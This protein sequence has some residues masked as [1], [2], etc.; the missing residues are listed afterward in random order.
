[1]NLIF[2]HIK[3]KNLDSTIERQPHFT[4]LLANNICIL[5]IISYIYAK[6]RRNVL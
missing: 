4:K 6:F 5:L 2:I 1:M 3:T